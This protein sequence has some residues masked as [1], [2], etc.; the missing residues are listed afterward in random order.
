[1]GIPDWYWDEYQH[2][3]TDCANAGEV[4]RYDRRMAEF[5]DVDTE[6]RTA[7][8]GLEIQPN[9]LLLEVGSGT[10]RLARTAALRCRRWRPQTSRAISSSNRCC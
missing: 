3:G 8:D 9:D 5:R 2:S 7:L 1:M 4:R 10:G 6:N